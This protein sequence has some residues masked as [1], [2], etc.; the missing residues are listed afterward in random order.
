MI[1]SGTLAFVADDDHLLIIKTYKFRVLYFSV[2]EKRIID[3]R[4]GKLGLVDLERH[5]DRRSSTIAP[6][7][8]DVRSIRSVIGAGVSSFIIT[9]HINTFWCRVIVGVNISIICVFHI[10][11]RFS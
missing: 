4:F 7:V 6:A 1:C 9:N 10:C 5:C 3:T 8:I 2:I 11:L